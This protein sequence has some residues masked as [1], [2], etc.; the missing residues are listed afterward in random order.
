MFSVLP[1]AH[2]NR[3][4]SE[5]IRLG[6]ILSILAFEYLESYH[7]VLCLSMKKLCKSSGNT[8]FEIGE[9]C[10]EAVFRQDRRY[11]P[12]GFDIASLRYMASPF[13]RI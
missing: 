13:D 11:I 8:G 4:V 6:K 1:T 9:N 10:P 12:S 5:G 2:T 7:F 3:R